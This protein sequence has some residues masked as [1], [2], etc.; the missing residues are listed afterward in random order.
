MNNIINFLIGFIAVEHLGF[1]YLEMFLWA[2]PK[3]QKIF[4]LEPE[5][6]E[7]SANLAANQGLYNGFLAAGLF[8]ALFHASTDFSYQLKLFFITCVFIAGLYGWM[9]VSKTI[10]YVQAIPSAITLIFLLF[11]YQK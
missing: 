8:W 10:L 3:G 11:L 5:F 1:L 9:T 4:K 2:T 6:A 7:Q